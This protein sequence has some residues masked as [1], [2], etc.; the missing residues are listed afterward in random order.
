[1]DHENLSKTDWSKK[2]KN[3]NIIIAYKKKILKMN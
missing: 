2:T 3:Y 1:M